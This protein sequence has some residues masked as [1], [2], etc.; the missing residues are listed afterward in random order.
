[1]NEV[2]NHDGYSSEDIECTDDSRF[3][4]SPLRSSENA[5]DVN[6]ESISEPA[7]LEGSDESITH[8]SDWSI[9]QR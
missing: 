8:F 6:M 9:F 4:P 7:M 3:T 1:M 5:E 2:W